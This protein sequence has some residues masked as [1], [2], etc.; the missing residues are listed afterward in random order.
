MLKEKEARPYIVTEYMG[1][2]CP[3][4]SSRRIWFSGRDSLFIVA[5]KVGIYEDF[6]AG[7][8]AE[9]YDLNKDPQGYYNINDKVDRA[10]I[11]YLLDA[12]KQ[13]YE[14]IKRDT[15]QFLEEL[16]AQA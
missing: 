14:E 15:N 16:S 4:I 9:V 10:K 3:D 13:R 2:G 6:E 12:I 8:L 1:P 5:Y 7:E 11:Q